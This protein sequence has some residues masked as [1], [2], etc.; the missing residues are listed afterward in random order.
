MG[1]STCPIADVQAPIE[2]VWSY[3]AQPSNYSLWWDA[4][5]VSIAPAGPAQQGQKILARTRALGRHWPVTVLVKAVDASR[6][7]LD[8]TTVLPLG[9]TVHNHIS[10]TP[11]SPESCRVT[12]G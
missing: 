3:L 12:F 6:H 8:L 11:L 9:V 4:K 10:C 1:L 5:T 2:R 7:A